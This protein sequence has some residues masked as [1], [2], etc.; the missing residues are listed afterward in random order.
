[1]PRKLVIFFAGA[2]LLSL[3]SIAIWMSQRPSDPDQ[4][5]ENPAASPE[6]KAERMKI[7]RERMKE[8]MRQAATGVDFSEEGGQGD[9]G[10]SDWFR[11]Q[12]VYPGTSYPKDALRKAMA[13]TA[14]TNLRTPAQPGEKVTSAGLPLSPE[15]G[16]GI[17]WGFLGPSTIPDGQTDTGAGAAL[18][19]VSGRVQ[20]LAV[21]PND[22]NIVF[23]G[24]AQGGIWKTTNALAAFPRWTPLTDQEASLAIG[25]IAIDP[26]DPDIIYVGTGEPAGSCDSYYG[27]GVLRSIDGGDSWTLL[28]QSDFQF[29]AISKMLVDPGSAGTTGA[30]T[31]FASLRLGLIGSGTSQCAVAPGSVT[32]GVYRSDD[33]GQTWTQL[34]LP[35]GNGGSQ[36]IHDMAVDPNDGNVLYVAVRG[37]GDQDVAGIWKSTNALGVTP[38]F[39]RINTGYIQTT[40]AA[41]SDPQTRRSR[42]AMCEGTPSTIYS[43]VEAL[44]STLWGIYKTTDSGATWSHLDGGDN[45]TGNITTGTTTVTRTTGPSF[46]ASMA[47]QRI[48]L[49]NRISRTVASV[50]DGDNLELTAAVNETLTGG[51]WSVGRYPLFCNGQCFY[52]L[53]AGCDPADAD[54]VYFG[55]NP[56][57]FANDLSGLGGRRDAWRSTDGG[58]SWTGI[59]Q[60]DGIAGGLHTDVHS[61]AFDDSTVPTRV[62]LGSDGGIW[63]TEDQG[64]SWTSMNT[65]MGITQFQSVALHPSDPSIILGGTQDNG[66]NIR[67]LD[68]E[69]NPKWFHT[70]FGDGGQAFIDQSDP[71]RMFHTYFNQTNNFQGPAKST[72]SGIDGPGNWEFA[73]GYFGFGAVYENGFIPGE[74]VLFYAPLA[75][76]EGTN[77]NV[78][79]FGT[80]SVYRAADPGFPTGAGDWTPVSPAI[81]GGGAVSW[82][83]AFPQAIGGFEVI[84]AG[85]QN[86]SI[87][88]SAD[89]DASTS[90]CPGACTSTWNDIHD[91]AVTPARFVTDMEVLRDDPTGNTIYV[92]FSGFNANT[93]ATPGHVFMTTNGLA[94]TPTWVNISGNLPDIPANAIAIDH[95]TTPETIYV[96]TD[97]GVYRSVNG[98]T[99]Y[100]YENDGHPV[101]AVFGLDR[102]P[103]TGQVVSSTHGRGMWEVLGTGT[104]DIFEDGFESG[105]TTAWSLTVQ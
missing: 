47:G 55:G 65:N 102:N 24:G 104:L 32:G 14:T 86:G 1:M 53:M 12:R 101:V 92:T 87:M 41:P 49:E 18:S 84:Y 16:G 99:T 21:H 82:I 64:A 4:V 67:R 75:Q 46:V 43:A 34:D 42:L 69:P 57:A 7:V 29:Q 61:V 72:A 83:E 5:V 52:N 30:T 79:Y 37:F 27:Q 77:P 17:E 25:S 94:P 58:D 35:P 39:T 88:V 103:F 28:G 62:Y 71:T 105:N 51:T 38:T 100:T 80:S 91:P 6:K 19:P 73:G 66:S 9:G 45:G 96:G 59:S 76:F 3:S 56:N 15:G 81:T 13:H 31:V 90:G 2:L 50:T 97:I 70:D 8:K 23:G 22:P 95:T 48:V 93:P 89:V 98:G 20:S 78:V 36:Q 11:Q 44:G 33:S 26:V 68:L 74:P 54:T 10:F 63:R 60:G 85:G 40:T